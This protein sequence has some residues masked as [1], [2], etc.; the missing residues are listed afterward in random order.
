MLVRLRRVWNKCL[1]QLGFQPPNSGCPC[2]STNKRRGVRF[3]PLVESFRKGARGNDV[4]WRKEKAFASRGVHEQFSQTTSCTLPWHDHDGAAE[5]E[6]ALAA[7]SANQFGGYGWERGCIPAEED[8]SD[9]D[10]GV[11]HGVTQVV[12]K[13]E[14]LEH[15]DCDLSKSV[16]LRNRGFRAKR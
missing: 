1:L 3:L 6:C 7:V 12:L 16:H 14:Q 2:E 15:S 4:R 13:M 10:D 11:G 8:A 9:G 5:I